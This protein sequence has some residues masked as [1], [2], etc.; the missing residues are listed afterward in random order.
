MTR[1]ADSGLL[2]PILLRRRHPRRRGPGTS[3]YAAAHNV[4]LGRARRRGRR[5]EGLPV[6]QSLSWGFWTDATGE[7]AGPSRRRASRAPSE[8]GMS[9]GSFVPLTP[10]QAR[11]VRSAR[12]RADARLRAPSRSGCRSRFNEAITTELRRRHRRP[13]L[14]CTGLAP[15]GPGTVASEA[16]RMGRRGSLRF[17]LRFVEEAVLKHSTRRSR[18]GIV[19][20]ERRRSRRS[21]TRL[22]RRAAGSTHLWPSSFAT[23]Q[24]GPSRGRDVR[25]PPPSPSTTQRP[26]ASI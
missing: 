11:M 10:S 3:A 26:L 6:V 14:A 22:S 21:R 13:P 23:P 15:R 8:D 9:K 4:A 1:E 5:A 25:Y 17:L 12:G 2:R 24:V 20:A 19:H 7:A 18:T 16:R